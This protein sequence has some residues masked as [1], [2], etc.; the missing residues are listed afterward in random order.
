MVL[1]NLLLLEGRLGVWEQLHFNIYPN[2]ISCQYN[3]ELN[4]L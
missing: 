1:G 4:N 2:I 3:I